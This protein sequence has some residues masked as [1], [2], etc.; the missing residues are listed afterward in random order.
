MMLRYRPDV[1]RSFCFVEFAIFPCRGVVLCK[2]A[3]AAVALAPVLD[4]ALEAR[5]AKNVVPV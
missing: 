4:L 3:E 5:S 2:V 1:R